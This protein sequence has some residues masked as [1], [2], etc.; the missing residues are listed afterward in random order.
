MDA[1]SN[2][3]AK[4]LRRK[5]DKHMQRKTQLSGRKSRMRLVWMLIGLLLTMAGVWALNRLN[6]IGDSW[7]TILGTSFTGLGS[8]VALFQWHEQATLETPGAAGLPAADN[9]DLREPFPPVPTN[10]RKGAIA[11]YTPRTWRGTTLHLVPGLQETF[12]PIVAASNVVEHRSAE[13]RQ[14]LC[15]FPAVPSGH[16]TLIAPSRQ[17]QA[18]I[19]V[20]PGHLA[21]IDWR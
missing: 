1:S 4:K 3:Q 8:I 20:Y 7:F 18:Q 6:V 21:E 16:Y 19:T 5:G 15:H 17:R 9:A 12:G 11:V 14:F 2:K 13:R 10:R